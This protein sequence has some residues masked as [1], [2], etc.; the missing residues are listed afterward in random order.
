MDV[1]M[2]DNKKVK[3]NFYDIM[4]NPDY[5]EINKDISGK[6][7]FVCIDCGFIPKNKIDTEQTKFLDMHCKCGCPAILASFGFEELENMENDRV[8]L[9]KYRRMCQSVGDWTTV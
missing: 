1:E 5:F 9:I 6:D 4:H 8:E 7:F 2:K 3:V